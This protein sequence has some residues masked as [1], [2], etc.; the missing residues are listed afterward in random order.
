MIRNNGWRSYKKDLKSLR[1][2]FAP[3]F[4]YL[5][6]RFQKDSDLAKKSSSLLD[7][8]RDVFRSVTNSLS[9][10]QWRSKILLHLDCLLFSTL[11]PITDS[12]VERHF[13][14]RRHAIQFQ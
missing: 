7:Y 10:V 12:T 14:N 1:T 11:I 4:D 8:F 2:H 13:A 3:S 9:G 5:L 6:L